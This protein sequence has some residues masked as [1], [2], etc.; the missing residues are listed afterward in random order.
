LIEV[1]VGRRVAEDGPADRRMD[2]RAVRVGAAVAAVPDVGAPDRD[3]V[4]VGRVCEEREAAALPL[5][6][7]LGMFVRV[8]LGEVAAAEKVPVGGGEG[9]EDVDVE[10]VVVERVV[11]MRDERVR[12]LDPDVAQVGEDL[13]VRLDHGCVRARVAADARPSGVVAER[14]PQRALAEVRPVRVRVRVLLSVGARQRA[15]GC[16]DP[17]AGAG[18]RGRAREED[19]DGQHCSHRG[20]RDHRARA[21]VDGPSSTAG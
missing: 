6:L 18:E 15:V 11:G 2:L 14:D 1:A 3:P 12:L 7:E 10:A 20:H 16:E 5:H 4:A 9:D 8:P 17:A 19:R 13:A 21:V